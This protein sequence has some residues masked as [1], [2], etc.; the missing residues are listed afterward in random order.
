VGKLDGKVAIVTGAGLGFGPGI[1]LALAGEG[2]DV[3]LVDLTLPPTEEIAKAIAELGR[4]AVPIAC[5]LGD[6]TQIEQM[7][8]KGVEELGP[9]DIL[10]NNGQRWGSEEGPAPPLLSLEEI[11][12]E[13]WDHTFEVGVKAA[14]RCSK[15]VLPHMQGRGGKIVNVGSDVGIRGGAKRAQY[16]SSTEALRALTK[17]TAFDWGQYGITVNVIAPSVQS[18]PSAAPAPSD[19]PDGHRV[20]TGNV[21][22]D[23]VG[24]VAVF[25]ASAGTDYVTG[26][27]FIVGGRV[28]I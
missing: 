4:R 15:A 26:Q 27:T 6:P 14:F 23:D 11:S 16:A 22:Q 12:D 2:A 9:I 5:D 3:V 18:D 21:T 1:S 13:S 8:A 24:A 28:V 20:I 10:V 17:C 7:V 25:L 19:D